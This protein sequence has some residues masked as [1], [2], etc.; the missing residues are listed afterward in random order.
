MHASC[1]IAGVFSSPPIPR[2]SRQTT[3]LAPMFST[4]P[5]FQRGWNEGRVDAP[6]PAVFNVSSPAMLS[7]RISCLAALLSV[8]ALQAQQP[9]TVFEDL[10][11]DG[12]RSTYSLPGS[13]AWYQNVPA[14]AGNTRVGNLAVH[15][16]SLDFVVNNESRSVW[17]YF[18]TVN[19][20]V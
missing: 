12:E 10:F 9:T 13:V 1:C 15:N 20:R 11:T 2:Y 17:T 8:S 16:G 19:L 6:T 3:S 7:F 14:S 5:N 4:M 18:P